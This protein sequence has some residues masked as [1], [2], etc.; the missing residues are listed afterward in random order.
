MNETN[1][2]EI[3]QVEVGGEIYEAEFAELA[4]W[5]FENSLLRQDK[6]RRGDLRWIEAQK[7][8]ALLKY[9]NDK[10]NGLPPPPVAGIT[11]QITAAAPKNLAA[12]TEDSALTQNVPDSSF[13]ETPIT[14][15]FVS[16]Q[17]AQKQFAANPR[18]N[19]NQA[20][21]AV[22][23]FCAVH[24]DVNAVFFCETCGNSFCKACPKSY[25]GTVK[26]C[27]FCGAL[28][29]SVKEV[30]ATRQA[31]FRYQSGSGFGFGDL[32]EAFAHPFRYKTS[33]IAGALIFMFFTLGQTASAVG[34]IF[35]VVAAIFCAMGANMLTFGILANTIESFSLGR[36]EANFMP[37]F[38]DFSLWEDVIHPFFLSIA[39]YL[40]SFGAFFL[41][42]V[43]GAYL[44]FSS[45]AAQTKAMQQQ[46]EKIPGTHYY[47]AQRTVEQSEQ[48]K[49]V[50]EKTRRQNEARLD[51]QEQI[52][53]A[54]PPAAING[55]EGEFQRMDEMIRETRKAQL[56]SAIGKSPETERKEF[57]QMVQ[58]LLGLAAPLVVVG[59]LALLWGIFY[60]PA[61][62]IVAGYTRSFTSAINPL[63]G[64]DTIRRL[65]FD[66]VK[67]LAMFV[68]LGALLLVV[69]SI[70]HF[71]LSPFDMPR[72]G[73]L[74]A[75]AVGS[76]FTFYF[77]IVFSC[78]LGYAIYKNSAK[79]KL[80]R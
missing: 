25:G 73:N 45:I 80:L 1:A 19:F 49:E 2:R 55:E 53:N 75:T 47:D 50:L 9:F 14:N 27:P 6:V 8:P 70:I 58:G 31:D 7:V 22:G 51:Q 79:L 30:Q 54:N 46:I 63:V 32:A 44:I 66:Y 37:D 60:F 26:I 18:N 68:L 13:G 36:L 48:V 15:S 56:E 40:S 65:G 42:V 20:A 23:E 72:M 71:V 52:A 62:C 38:E 3:W 59:F 35:M 5:V 4:Q 69:S 10:E 78:I 41:V 33:L 43:I 39:A 21:Q 11:T 24:E 57:Q 76:F 12:Q 29:K 77:S 74:P 61:A 17:A 67:I 28:C 16:S 64:L 34:G